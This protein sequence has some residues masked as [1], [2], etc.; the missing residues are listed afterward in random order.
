MTDA[1]MQTAPDAAI[2]TNDGVPLKQSLARATRRQRIQAL[3]LVMP[4]LLFLL[5]AFVMP[6]GEM[7]FRSVYSP[8]GSSVLPKF[9]KVIQEWDGKDLPPE[10]TFK[11]FVED[12]KL[13]RSNREIGA[14]V[15]NLATRVNYEIPGSRGLFT[16]TS[17]KLRNVN[18]GPYKEALITLDKRWA[19]PHIWRTLQRVG[20]DYTLS[21]YLAATDR[22]Y[23]ENNN[24]VMADPLYQIYL[25]ILWKTL[26]LSALITLIC[27]IIAYPV[28]Y[29]LATLPLRT[30]NLLMIMVLLP[31]WT[32]LLVRTTAWIA[33][34]Q[35]EGVLNNI[36]VFANI[37]S[38]EN[39][40]QM[41][42]NQTGTIIA[43]VHILL[44]FMILPLYSVMKTIPPYYMRAARSLGATGT[45]SFIKVYFPQTLPGI[46]AG[47]LLVFILAMGYYITPALVGGS[48]GL[49]ISNLIADHIKKT[50]NWSLGSALGAILLVIVLVFYWIY[51]KLIGVDNLKFG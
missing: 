44:P 27:L 2:T 15:G 41:I 31:F 22:K 7:L 18:E 26:W 32:S 43:M 30:S 8:V 21:F 3:M 51:N 11:V 4:L 39:R 45:Y 9:S 16:S 13:A 37:I 46:G 40:I 1:T 28:A 50:L 23:D 5:I 49:L 6:I 33:M 25:P 12:M 17:R 36:F 42:Y 34:L 10:E 47:T 38:D 29:L 35:K 20:Q 19:D 48:D 24:I 14:T